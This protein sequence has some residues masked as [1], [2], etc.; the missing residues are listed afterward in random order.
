LNG[1]LDATLLWEANT[2]ASVLE[3]ELEEHKGDAQ[4]AA[5]EV[6]TEMGLRDADVAVFEGTRLPAASSG[7]T[8]H[9]LATNVGDGRTQS[10]PLFLTTS[11]S[12]DASRREVL[13]PVLRAER[14]YV[15]LAAA[16]LSGVEAELHAL[17]RL[18]FLAVPLMILAAGAGGY[19]LATRGLAPLVAMAG[20]AQHITDKNLHERLQVAGA[21]TELSQ[22]AGSFNGLLERLDRSFETMRRFAAD[23]SHEL[24][25]PLSVIRGEADVALSKQRPAEEYRESL[26]VVRDE[27]RRLSRLVDDLLHL[28][29]ADAGRQPVSVEEFF[30][31]DLLADCCRSL[32]QTAAK[33]RIELICMAPAQ[34]LFRGDQDLLRRLVVNLLDNAIRY[35]PDGGAVSVALENQGPDIRIVVSDTGIGIP[36]ECAEHVFDRFYRVD[37]AR[38]RGDGEFGLGLSIAKWIAES[39]RGTLELSRTSELGSTFTVSLSR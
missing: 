34:V 21:A 5:R 23:A 31:N 27:A 22:L 32:Q 6:M 10:G 18:F 26:E 9:V 13:V 1:R 15:V 7:A 35:T 17:A 16:P 33:K 24:R 20:Q 36:A 12:Q 2:A 39:H 14:R 28:A 11:G 4:A 3:V 37:Q 38:S 30:L 19:L 8:R 25:T 29:R